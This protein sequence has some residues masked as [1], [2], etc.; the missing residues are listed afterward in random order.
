MRILEQCGGPKLAFVARVVPASIACEAVEQG[1]RALWVA[2]AELV[3]LTPGEQADPLVWGQGRLPVKAGGLVERREPAAA[4]AH[5]ASWL[6]AREVAGVGARVRVHL[7]DPL[8]AAGDA[9]REEYAQCRARNRELP[10]TLLDLLDA[11]DGVAAEFRRA[12]GTVKWQAFL[13]EGVREREA[14]RWWRGRRRRER[15][16]GEL[17]GHRWLYG[18]DVRGAIMHARAFRVAVRQRLGL[19]VTPVVGAPVRATCANVG[20]HGTQCPMPLD[21]WGYHACTCSLGGG[22]V[23][24]HDLC[25]DVL[26]GQLRGHGVRVAVERWVHELAHVDAS[27]RVKEARLDLVVRFG[28]EVFYVDVSAYHPFVGSGRGVG[29]LR[30]DWLPAHQEREK[31]RTYPTRRGGRRVLPDGAVVPVVCSSLGKLGDVGEDFLAACQAAKRRHRACDPQE[32]PDLA[33]T[34]ESLVVYATACNVLRAFGHPDGSQR[35]DGSAGPAGPLAP[36]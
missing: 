8:S 4:F 36:C 28:S 35:A 29:Q 13:S 25:R 17:L 11:E 32:L 14:Q 15:R 21:Q 19:P 6:D 5:L 24:R 16:R 20:Q 3:G 7:E 22:L 12:D 34:V 26:C 2:A 18:R 31:Y 9:L 1:D 23:G 27:G 10:R 33:G 30:N